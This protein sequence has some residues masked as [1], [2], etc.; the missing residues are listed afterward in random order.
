MPKLRSGEEM[1]VQGSRQDGVQQLLSCAKT[2]EFFAAIF[3]PARLGYTDTKNI[4]A[5]QVT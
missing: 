1:Q 2:E 5:A 3:V 4:E